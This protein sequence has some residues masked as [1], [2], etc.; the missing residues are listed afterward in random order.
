[1]FKMGTY[2]KWNQNVIGD[3][4]L[5]AAR[6]AWSQHGIGYANRRGWNGRP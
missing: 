4:V 1:M 5:A 3:R 6:Q 2:R